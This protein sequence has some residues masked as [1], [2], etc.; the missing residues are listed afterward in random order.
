MQ[1]RR[2]VLL[3]ARI[4]SLPLVPDR[5]KASGSSLDTRGSFPPEPC[6]AAPGRV[7]SLPGPPY[8]A[9]A[10]LGQVFHQDLPTVAQLPVHPLQPRGDL[11]R[12][13]R[14]GRG[15]AGDLARPGGGARPA[16]PRPGA[17]PRRAAQ[18][19]APLA[20]AASRRRHLPGAPRLRAPREARGEAETERGRRP[21]RGPG[22]QRPQSGPRARR[23]GEA[24]RRRRNQQ[25]AGGERKP[26]RRGGAQHPL[27]GTP[28][29]PAV[30]APL[31]LPLPGPRALPPRHL[32]RRRRARGL[33]PPPPRKASANSPPG[34]L[35]VRPLAGGFQGDSKPQTPVPARPPYGTPQVPPSCPR[36]S[37][38]RAA[39]GLH[40]G[41][42]A[43]QTQGGGLGA[44]DGRPVLRIFGEKV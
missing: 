16:R 25:P 11:L 43:P 13:Q 33:P 2:A 20:T 5:P 14:G 12:V 38:A 36:M 39:R 35:G 8:L 37:R 28:R 3:T 4:P 7:A 34:A 29:A 30:T 31:A 15:A 19:R 24:G 42:Q 18:A 10:V 22:G 21:G 32:C 40:T 27:A 41:I 44:P 9:A 1:K 26:E 6:P 17:R 23:G